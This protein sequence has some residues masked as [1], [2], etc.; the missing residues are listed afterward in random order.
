M[1]INRVRK[2]G[3]SA[4]LSLQKHSVCPLLIA[5]PVIANTSEGWAGSIK[6]DASGYCG[7]VFLASDCSS[8]MSPAAPCLRCKSPHITFC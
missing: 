1:Q 8:A 7:V 6:K 2:G 3:G 5:L 4:S